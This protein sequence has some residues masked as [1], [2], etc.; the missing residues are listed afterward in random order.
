MNFKQILDKA[1]QILGK[2]PEQEPSFNGYSIDAQRVWEAQEQRKQLTS[3]LQERER[4]LAAN[5]S[6]QTQ[7]I[8]ISPRIQNRRERNI[9]KRQER[10]VLIKAKQEDWKSREELR[11]IR[12]KINFEKMQQSPRI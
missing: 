4:Q 8:S 12:L 9:A 3:A 5:P 2:E 11:K 6:L 10:L 1:K 7:Y